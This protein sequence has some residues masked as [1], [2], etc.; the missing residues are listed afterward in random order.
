MRIVLGHHL[1]WVNNCGFGRFLFLCL[2]EKDLNAFLLYN[3]QVSYLMYFTTNIDNS[4]TLQ[5]L[6]VLYSLLCRLAT[7]DRFYS[8]SVS[9][10][11]LLVLS[12][13]SST[14][15]GHGFGSSCMCH[16]VHTDFSNVYILCI[17]LTLLNFF[18]ISDFQKLQ[19][20]DYF[21]LCGLIFMFLSSICTWLFSQPKQWENC[22]YFLQEGMNLVLHYLG[23][24]FHTAVLK[25]SWSCQ[26]CSM[27]QWCWE[28]WCWAWEDQS[29]IKNVVSLGEMPGSLVWEKSWSF[30]RLAALE[31][32]EGTRNS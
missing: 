12:L 10:R 17:R 26:Q 16:R 7:T 28:M 6:T 29:G 5:S 15:V 4:S 8:A 18:L 23:L 31:M 19:F 27:F 9:S 13:L 1:A 21:D 32:C 25:K 24:L 30:C 14:F 20:L 3:Y 22:L 2:Q 11:V